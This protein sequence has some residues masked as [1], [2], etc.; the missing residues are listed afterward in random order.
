MFWKL[1]DVFMRLMEIRRRTPF[2]SLLGL[3]RHCDYWK[4]PRMVRLIE[5][6]ENYIND[7]DGCCYGL[8]EQ[9]SHPFHVLVHG[10]FMGT[11]F[12]I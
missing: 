2:R 7:F 12:I 10:C 5:E 1:F 3:P 8:R 4:D 6:T 9:F 11:L